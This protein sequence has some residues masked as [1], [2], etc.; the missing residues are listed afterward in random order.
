MSENKKIKILSCFYNNNY[1]QEIRDYE[2]AFGGKSCATVGVQGR[3][4]C[5]CLPL[6]RGIKVY[7]ET[8]VPFY[9]FFENVHLPLSSPLLLL[10]AP[11]CS[12][13]SNCPMVEDKFSWFFFFFIWILEYYF[14]W[15][16]EKNRK[17]WGKRKLC[18]EKNAVLTEGNIGN[19]YSLN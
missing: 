13:I 3:Q 10:L 8:K 1:S 5:F 14:Y 9:S 7:F 6:S 16:L 19:Q 11:N 18:S 12:V 2:S 15:A 17:L 4:N